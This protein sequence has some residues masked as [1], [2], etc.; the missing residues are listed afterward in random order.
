MQRSRTASEVSTT[1]KIVS[2]LPARSR[3]ARS[4]G[5][6]LIP[7]SYAFVRTRTRLRAQRNG[8]VLLLLV[9]APSTHAQEFIPEQVVFPITD[10]KPDIRFAAIS[11][12]FGTG[13]V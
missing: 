9:Y 11:I 5:Q 7:R 12:K 1:C 6:N 3:T 8:L 2:F 4:T 10:F 13:F